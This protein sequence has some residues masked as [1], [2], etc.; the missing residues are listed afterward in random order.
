MSA[1]RLT[2]EFLTWR[3]RSARFGITAAAIALL[4][5]AALFAALAIERQWL[6]PLL[7][8]LRSNGPACAAFAAFFSALSVAQRR[9]LMRAQFPRSWLAAVP[10]RS[11]TAR[12]E[13][14]LIETLPASIAVA[15]VSLLA[16][17]LLPALAFA[18]NLNLGAILAVWAYLSGGVAGGVALSFLIPRPKPADLPPGSR[19]VPKPRIN[20]AA[21]IRA[22]L[23]ALGRWPIRQ[24]FAWAQP[25]VVARALVPVLVMMPLGTKADDAMIAIALFGVLSAMTLL[26]GATISVSRAA[27]GWLA[28]LPLR[29]AAVI[30]AFLLPACGVNAA[31]SVVAALL[32]LV[33]NL[34]Y[35]VSATVAALA[36]LTGCTALAIA[37]FWNTRP[38]RAP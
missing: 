26:T 18:P 17:V 15:A 21:L 35:R 31:A 33:F 11:A 16:A 6:A 22:S 34:A 13:A 23:A 28:P 9:N 1:P 19:Y 2:A 25:K 14:L 3:A 37:L 32:L 27:R 30:R 8:W 38:R 36:A 12:C 4:I 5:L 24:M 7:Q 29:Q 20:R 10:V